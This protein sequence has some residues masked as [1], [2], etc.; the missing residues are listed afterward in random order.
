MTDPVDAGGTNFAVGPATVLQ[1]K[2]RSASATC[3]DNLDG[4]GLHPPPFAMAA[5]EATRTG[6]LVAQLFPFSLKP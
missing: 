1:G 6:F 5:F 4:S 2:G 3:R